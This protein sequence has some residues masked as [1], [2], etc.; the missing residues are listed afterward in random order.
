MST[1]TLRT[2]VAALLLAC[3]AGC[4]SGG[5]GAV[6]QNRELLTT[7][8]IQGSGGRDAFEVV[9]RLRPLWLRSRGGRSVSHLGTSIV[10]FMNGTR[11]GGPESLRS[12]PVD[13]VRTIRY[14]D[15]PRASAELTGLGSEHVEGAIVVSTSE[16]R[17]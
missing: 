3:A 17:P 6:G 1:T 2:L 8:Q 12:I 10:V 4:A 15:G 14:L 9:E 5:T 11:M 16:S 13:L 7:E